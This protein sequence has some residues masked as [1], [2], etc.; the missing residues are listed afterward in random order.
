MLATTINDSPIPPPLALSGKCCDRDVL[1]LPNASSSSFVI[2]TF[3]FSMVLMGWGGAAGFTPVVGIFFFVG[4]VLLLFAMVFEWVMG[5]FFP[6]M[7]MG[8]FAV[9]WLSFGMLQ[10]V[11]FPNPTSE[12]KSL[13]ERSQHSALVPLTRRPPIRQALPRPSTTP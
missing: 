6:M 7:V 11:C 1:N 13:T 3:T 5:N 4:P 8:L 10:L 2:S 12:I 9:F